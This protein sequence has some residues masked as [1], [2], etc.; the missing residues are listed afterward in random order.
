MDYRLL[1]GSEFTA[2]GVSYRIDEIVEVGTNGVVR[3]VDVRTDRSKLFRLSQV[4]ESL[5]PDEI[6]ELQV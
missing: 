6:I 1:I 4:L 3:G 5:V 2:N